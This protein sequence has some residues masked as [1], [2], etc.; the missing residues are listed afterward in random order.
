MKNSIILIND[1]DLEIGYGEKMDV[2]IKGQLHRAFSLFIASPDRCRV[3]IQKRARDKYHSAGL[4]TNACCS[5]PRKGVTIETSI[6]SRAFE[7]LGIDI[8]DSLSFELSELGRF[9]YKKHFDLCTEYEIDHVFLLYINDDIMLHPNADEVD[10]VKWIDRLDLEA[11][12]LAN[13]DAFT[14][15]FF[16]VYNIYIR[17]ELWNPTTMR[18]PMSTELDSLIKQ[19]MKE[20]CYEEL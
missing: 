7:E 10:E 20:I 8:S 2:H 9:K 3:L 13:P 17:N 18:P 19:K 12:I 15:W 16:A 6:R 11:L 5:H 1:D 4:W 14:A